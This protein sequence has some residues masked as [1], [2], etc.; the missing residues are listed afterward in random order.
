MKTVVSIVCVT[1]IV[2]Y[3]LYLGLDTLIVKGGIAVLAGLGGFA[4]GVGSHLLSK[5][6]SK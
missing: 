2:L 6:P 3:S 5:P 4:A 1:L